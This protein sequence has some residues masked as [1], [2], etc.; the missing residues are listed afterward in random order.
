M[1]KLAT[2]KLLESRVTGQLAE[3]A[4]SIWIV[5]ALVEQPKTY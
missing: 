4:C 1:L 3:L 5:S 2:K